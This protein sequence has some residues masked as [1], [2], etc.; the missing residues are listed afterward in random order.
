MAVQAVSNSTTS[1]GI[2][3]FSSMSTEDFT[4]IIFSELSNQDPLSP[5]DTNALLQQISTIR[6]IQ[7][8]T[9][10]S[11]SLQTLVSQ[12]EFASA[13]TLIGQPVSGVTEEYERAEGVVR[14]VSRTANGPVLTLEDGNRIPINWLDTITKPAA[15]TTTP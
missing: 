5:N 3:G 7:S 1:T 15:T 9:D 2:N 14:S 4:K 12:N 8:D 11:Q 10:L 6:A 13:A